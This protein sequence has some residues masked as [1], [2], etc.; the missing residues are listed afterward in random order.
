MLLFADVQNL[1]E[2]SIQLYLQPGEITLTI[3][4]KR[5]APGLQRGD[6]VG[7]WIAS[8][9]ASEPMKP[10]MRTPN[11]ATRPLGP[12]RLVGLTTPVD[13]YRGA[14]LSEGRLVVV[15]IKPPPKGQTDP[16][17]DALQ[18]AIA[19]TYGR[20]GNEGGVLSVEYYR[21]GK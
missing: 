12:F 16:D 13:P 20:S 17:L 5:V 7:V 11:G 8:R 10:G 4:V 19:G 15:A 3:P 18:E 14:G 2:Q 9:P 1:D 21:G 6:P